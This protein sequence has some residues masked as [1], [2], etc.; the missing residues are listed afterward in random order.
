M[1]TAL[2]PL[3]KFLSIHSPIGFLEQGF[4]VCPVVRVNGLAHRATKVNSVDFMVR[5]TNNMHR[6]FVFCKGVKF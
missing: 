1:R 2:G 4:R 6:I 5:L 3:R